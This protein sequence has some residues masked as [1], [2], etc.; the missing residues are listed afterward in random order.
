MKISSDEMYEKFKD[1]DFSDAKRVAETPHLARLQEEAGAIR[2]GKE[3][4]EQIDLLA[5]AK[6]SNRSAVVREA[7]IRYLEGNEDLE[8]AK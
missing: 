3:L 8:L 2:L 6:Q 7:V 5:K 1:Y 4:E